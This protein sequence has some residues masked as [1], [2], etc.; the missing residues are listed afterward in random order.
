MGHSETAV[1]VVEV[2]VAAAIAV[3]IINYSLISCIV[4]T[5]H[6]IN[7]IA[8]VLLSVSIHI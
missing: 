3:I 8:T 5:F 2:S 4:L 1:V 7:D 6:A